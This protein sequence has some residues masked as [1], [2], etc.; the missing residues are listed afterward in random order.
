MSNFPSPF[1]IS[2]DNLAKPENIFPPLPFQNQEDNEKYILLR[3]ALELRYIRLDIKLGDINIEHLK[4]ILSDIVNIFKFGKD[5]DKY[6]II[7]YNNQITERYFTYHKLIKILIKWLNSL[8]LYKKISSSLTQKFQNFLTKEIYSLNF[9]SILNKIIE[10]YPKIE[11]HYSQLVIYFRQIE[12]F[13]QAK[14]WPMTEL[15]IENSPT[16]QQYYQENGQENR[17]LNYYQ[18]FTN[19]L[20]KKVFHKNLF[21]KLMFAYVQ[22]FISFIENS[23]EFTK[24]AILYRGIYGKLA[25]AIMT[26]EPNDLVTFKGFQSQTYDYKIAKMYMQEDENNED[27]PIE[28]GLLLNLKYPKY[29]KF[30]CLNIEDGESEFLSYPNSQYQ[31]EKIYINN[32]IFSCDLKYV[33]NK[34]EDIKINLVDF[35]QKFLTVFKYIYENAKNHYYIINWFDIY[36][37]FLDHQEKLEEIIFEKILEIIETNFAEKKGEEY[38]L[39]FENYIAQMVGLMIDPDLVFYLERN[40]EMTYEHKKLDNNILSDEIQEGIIRYITYN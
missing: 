28:G 10:H 17:Y 27:N 36:R 35:D 25:K 9:I 20:L 12:N 26:L 3:E 13:Y 4:F 40:P 30:L 33:G 23:D 8:Y 34:M 5:N 38:I 31:F 19:K 22:L 1:T 18:T 15:K 24:E 16:L 6:I 39:A 29:F 7:F 14:L 32:L 21:S 2:L 11:E 37:Y